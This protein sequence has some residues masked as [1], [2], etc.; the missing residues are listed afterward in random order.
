MNKSAVIKQFDA[1]KLNNIQLI[2]MLSVHDK[3]ALFIKQP[4]WTSQMYSQIMAV[5]F[6]D[7]MSH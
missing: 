1:S 5:R 6:N 4:P 3:T 2:Q 7:I